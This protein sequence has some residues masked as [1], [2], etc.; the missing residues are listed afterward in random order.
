MPQVF[1]G[2]PDAG[3]DVPHFLECFAGD[4]VLTMSVML[5]G[6][7]CARPVDVRYGPQCDVTAEGDRLIN[8]ARSG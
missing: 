8:D 2:L 3:G 7:P 1:E 6:M 4:A 5:N